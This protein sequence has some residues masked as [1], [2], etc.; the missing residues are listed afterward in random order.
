MTAPRAVL[1]AVFVLLLA[2]LPLAAQ[3]R[4]AFKQGVEAL[5]LERFEDAAQ[6]L[7]R[8]VR[9]DGRESED[10]V[11]LSGV[12]SRPYLP[13][14]FLGQAL[15]RAGL[16]NCS[17]ALPAL[18]ESD[19]QGVVQGFDRLFKEL[20]EARK[21][22]TRELLPKALADAERGSRAAETAASALA[23]PLGTPQLEA[24]RQRLL[25]ELEAARETLATARSNLDPLA[26]TAIT[27]RL[28][29]LADALDGLRRGQDQL[30]STR[31]ANAF[32]AASGSAREAVT[33]TERAQRQLLDLIADPRH[34]ALR[35]NRLGEAPERHAQALRQIRQRLASATTT[36]EAEAVEAD[37]RTLTRTLEDL[38]QEVSSLRATER[39]EPTTPTPTLT[40]PPP[41]SRVPNSGASPQGSNPAPPPDLIAAE[42]LLR[43]LRTEEREEADT[44]LA[45]Q[46]SRLEG[47]AA[48]ARNGDP[49]PERLRA[50]TD[51]L[52]L[53]AGT[54]R[55]FTGDPQGALTLLDALNL[56]DGPLAAHGQLLRAASLFELYRLG[57]ELDPRLL[58]A[59]R[60]AARESQ[61]LDPTLEPDPRPF[62]PAFRAFFAQA[63]EGTP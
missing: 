49:A 6:A 62:S 60:A 53:L 12:F 54:Q 8:A 25:G 14:F 11:F 44:L 63:T 42:A 9:E 5:D 36:A 18:A 43:E 50:S 39:Q 32:L 52:R 16:G 48:T 3:E 59:A 2:S 22:C 47:L 4:A 37:A 1:L 61:R 40:T 23:A 34:G 26:L 31:Q 46:R 13:H 35:R 7:R 19:R 38:T 51:A 10:R 24:E 17:E 55:L 20:K 33:S 58:D 41:S 21:R 30:A 27:E 57:G 56:V 28:D 29:S 15:Y 45:L